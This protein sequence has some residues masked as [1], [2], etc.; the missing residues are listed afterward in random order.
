MI[1]SATHQA[2]GR[3]AA[4]CGWRRRIVRTMPPST[5]CAVSGNRRDRVF[6]EDYHRAALSLPPTA[7]RRNRSDAGRVR[8]SIVSFLPFFVRPSFLFPEARLC[9]PHPTVRLNSSF[10]LSRHPA[11]PDFSGLTPGYGNQVVT[12]FWDE[13]VSADFE[14]AWQRSERGAIWSQQDSK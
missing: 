10:V 6:L 8:E 13:E 1:P 11:R 5:S 4:G 14:A 12:D 9:A 7:R 2:D 3:G